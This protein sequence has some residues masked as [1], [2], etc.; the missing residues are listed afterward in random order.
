MQKII[1]EK[2]ID[3]MYDEKERGEEVVA[4]LD[5]NLNITHYSSIE[6]LA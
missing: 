1:N 3:E 4:H 6:C 5:E 2:A